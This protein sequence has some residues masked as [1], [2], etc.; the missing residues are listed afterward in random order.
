MIVIFIALV[1]WYVFLESR[2]ACLDRK[3]KSLK[4]GDTVFVLF[5]TLRKPA[6]VTEISGDTVNVTLDETRSGMILEKN[7]IYF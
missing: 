3:R 6:T 2:A 7:E 5:G 1:A 4:V